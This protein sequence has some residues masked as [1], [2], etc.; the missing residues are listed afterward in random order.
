MDGQAHPRFP[1]RLRNRAHRART[2]GRHRLESEQTDAT[3]RGRLFRLLTLLLMLLSQALFAQS[4]APATPPPATHPVSL[5][6][7]YSE[8][9]VVDAAISPSGR[10][11]AVV[12]R[13]ATDDI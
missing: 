4:S 2:A 8:P 6:E 11:L 1:P 10:Y 12:M 9:N 7:L 3:G 13:R 5:D